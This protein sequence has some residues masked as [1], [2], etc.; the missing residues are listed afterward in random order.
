MHTVEGLPLVG[1]PPARLSRF[2][3]RLKRLIDIVLAVVGLLLTAPLFAYIALRV[4]LD[5][6]GPSFSVRHGWD[7]TWS[8][9]PH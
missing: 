4:K 8:R 5:S 1:L 6:P 9:S 7:S 3:R 2:S